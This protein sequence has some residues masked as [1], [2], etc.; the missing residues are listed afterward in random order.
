MVILDQFLSFGEND[1]LKFVGNVEHLANE[2]ELRAAPIEVVVF[3]VDLEIFVAVEEIGEESDAY[4]EC[5]DGAAVGHCI[6]FRFVDAF[7]GGF[8][9]SSND[10]GEVVFIEFDLGEILFV[11]S[12]GVASG[13]NE[14]A[15]I[16]EDGA[17]HYCVE[18]NNGF[19]NFS[20]FTEKYIIDF[21]V[22]VD[23]AERFRI[24]S[25]DVHQTAGETALA[26]DKI[27]FG[28]GHFYPTG[29]GVSERGFKLFETEIGVVKIRDCDMKVIGGEV[30]EFVE[31]VAE[32]DGG[33]IRYIWAR[34]DIVGG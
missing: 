4:G 14:V 20:F 32:G 9:K 6:P 1:A 12:G 28:G 22:V 13:A 19:A 8:G 7:T 21:G 33:L 27:K 29:D 5:D 15:D 17:W 3:A 24:A 26:I 25:D 30:A 18:I 2:F 11:F 16:E 31:K 23:N 34:D 10:R